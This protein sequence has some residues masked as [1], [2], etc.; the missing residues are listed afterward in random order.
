MEEQLSTPKEPIVRTERGLVL[1]GT[2]ITLYEIMDYLKADWPPQL[3]RDWL[4][5]TE[6]Q[7]ADAAAYITDHPEAVEAEYHYVVEH[8]EE[9][10][11][12]WEERNRTRLEE[13]ATLPPKPGLEAAYRKL[14]ERKAARKAAS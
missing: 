12:F 11:R 5:I 7:F 13:I 3:I 1:A 2:R 6:Q 8:A 9:N 10:R 14:Q 4:D